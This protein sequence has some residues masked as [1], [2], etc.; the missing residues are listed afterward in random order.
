MS[1]RNGLPRPKDQ[2]REPVAR[3]PLPKDGRG[4]A[5]SRIKTLWK[6]AADGTS[7]RQFARQ[8]SASNGAG[9]KVASDWLHNKRCNPSHPTLWL[10]ATRKRKGDSSKPKAR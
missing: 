2:Q 6:R 8:L 9:S 4:H 3:R 10:G 1:S 7:L 5:A